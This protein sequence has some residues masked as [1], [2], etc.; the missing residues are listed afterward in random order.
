MQS[1]HRQKNGKQYRLFRFFAFVSKQKI[2]AEKN[3]CEKD[4]P[5][6]IPKIEKCYLHTVIIPHLR[7]KNNQTTPIF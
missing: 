5:K 7:V 6:K 2:Q 4:Y 3:A 1:K